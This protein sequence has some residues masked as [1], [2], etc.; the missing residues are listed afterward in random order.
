MNNE[1]INSLFYYACDSGNIEIILLFIHYNTNINLIYDESYEPLFSTLCARNIAQ[2]KIIY[3]FK[4]LL[5]KGGDHVLGMPL[6]TSV[7]GT[8]IDV[9]NFYCF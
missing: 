3:L 8:N 1:E 5:Q 9:L 2:N 7:K 4:L 6:F